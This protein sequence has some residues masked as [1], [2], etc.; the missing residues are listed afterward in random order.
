MGRSLS[1]QRF[2]ML[3]LGA[4]AVVAIVLAAVGV[5]GVLSYVVSRRTPEMG[6]RMALGASRGNVIG[7]VAGQGAKLAVL[8]LGIGLAL[9]FVASR[10]LGSL[11]YGVTP[12]DP[13][14]FAA[15]AGA[16]FAIAMLATVL[17]ARRA[18]GIAPVEALRHE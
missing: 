7:L 6:V 5:H 4:F 17:P 18:T 1:Q 16:V 2:T 8:G 10:L 14:T 11:L 12:T 15:V 3:L 13:A 9:A